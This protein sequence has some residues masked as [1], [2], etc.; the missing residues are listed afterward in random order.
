MSLLLLLINLMQRSQTQ[1]LEGHSSSQ[2]S[3]THTCFEV[4]INPEELDYLDQM[5]LIRAGAKLCRDVAL[6]E[7]SLRPLI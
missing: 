7:L 6:Q 1:F 2:F 5:C 4:S 3:S